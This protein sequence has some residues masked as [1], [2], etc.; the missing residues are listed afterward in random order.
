MPPLLTLLLLALAPADD[1]LAP[2]DIAALLRSG[3]PG[4][5]ILATVR[6]CGLR[7]PVDSD[8]LVALRALGAGDDLVAELRRLAPPPED[9]LRDCTLHVD[10]GRN[11]S[12]R[13][14]AG[15]TVTEQGQ[16]IAIAAPSGAGRPAVTLSIRR[17]ERPSGTPSG[18]LLLLDDLLARRAAEIT[19]DRRIRA[20]GTWPLPAVGVT[21]LNAAFRA[22]GD[23]G[24]VHNVVWFPDG[25]SILAVTST[26]RGA[27]TGP[28]YALACATL[29]SI[30]SSV[31][32]ATLSHAD[33]VREARRS[34]RERLFV[35]LADTGTVEPVVLD[36]RGTILHAFP[37][38]RFE[39]A[40]AGEG[41]VALA[42]EREVRVFSLDGVAR[43]R[44]NIGAEGARARD[45]AF[46][47]F[48]DRIHVLL[49]RDD[50]REVVT[51]ARTAGGLAGGPT[52]TAHG[53]SRLLIGADGRPRLRPEAEPP[54]GSEWL[55]E[56]C[57]AS[58][59]LVL[60]GGRLVLMDA[61][62]GG[63]RTL[64]DPGTRGLAEARFSPSGREILA[65]LRDGE[66]LVVGRSGGLPVRIPLA[67]AATSVR[68]FL[69][70]AP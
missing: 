16:E 39:A 2:R 24:F 65:R 4:D 29:S 64:L 61:A 68:S 5:A 27:L 66:V 62:T 23:G 56:A 35:L 55:D 67:K 31:A 13:L 47:R 41:H 58:A 38:G 49:D 46:D 60:A 42:G 10:E 52:G 25:D 32:T 44:K 51:L 8:T 40:A 15:F 36:R 12:I 33:W 11:L 57:D 20:V 59:I 21:G 48:G 17:F 63:L 53:A 7:D 28:R 69:V 3:I 43:G 50:A 37:S 26:I 45:I 70:A 30:L 9:P 14:P 19:K 34:A 1:P 18:A 54:E 22:G 6:T